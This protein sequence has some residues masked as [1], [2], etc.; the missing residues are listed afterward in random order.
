MPGICGALKEIVCCHLL[1]P[2]MTRRQKCWFWS[3]IMPV[4]SADGVGYAGADGRGY[5]GLMAA[6]PH[7][8]KGY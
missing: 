6:R 1:F 8:R 3:T 7:D 5:R 4:E 2:V